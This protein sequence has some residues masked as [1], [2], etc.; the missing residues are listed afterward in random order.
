MEKDKINLGEEVED[1][2]TGYTGIVVAITYWINGCTRCGIQSTELEK[3]LPQE[4]QWIDAPQLEV[5]KK[6]ENPKSKSQNRPG[7]PKPS[8]K[9]NP[10]D[11]GH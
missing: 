5:I 9:H 3:G 10:I 4:P 8:P 2:I 1:T 6:A 7:G 11:K